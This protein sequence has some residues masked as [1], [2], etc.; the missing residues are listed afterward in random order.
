MTQP[1][2]PLTK[3][4]RLQRELSLTT[5]EPYLL[6]SSKKP[7]HPRVGLSPPPGTFKINVDGAASHDSSPSSIGITIRDSSG[8]VFSAMSKVLPGCYQADTVEAIAL[9]QGILALEMNIT[10]AAFESDALTIMESLNAKKIGGPLGH[11]LHGILGLLS[12]FPSWTLRHLKMEHN[13][14]AHD[15]AQLV[16]TSRTTQVWKGVTS[17]VLQYLLHQKEPS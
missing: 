9:E 6:L 11:I 2:Q 8:H 1:Q 14:V 13:K 7:I 15:L 17:P 5:K 10:R 3:Y 16:R 12:S 4:G